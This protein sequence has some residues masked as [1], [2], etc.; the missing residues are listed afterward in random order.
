M[1]VC[2]IWQVA[3]GLDNATQSRKSEKIVPFSKN[4]HVTYLVA[5]KSQNFL[6]TTIWEESSQVKKIKKAKF[7]RQSQKW[8]FLVRFGLNLGLNNLKW[9]F[10][11]RFGL[12]LGTMLTFFRL[13]FKTNMIFNYLFWS[14]SCNVES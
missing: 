2:H 1:A 8:L 12:N 5:R 3:N 14:H 13:F 4:V 6:L 7:C 9:P 10:L 11:V